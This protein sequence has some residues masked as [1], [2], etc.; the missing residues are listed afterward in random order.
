MDRRQ[1]LKISLTAISAFFLARIS[2][3]LPRQDTP[4]PGMKEALFYKSSD[5]LAG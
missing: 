4:A 1:F 2:S 3:W 5:D